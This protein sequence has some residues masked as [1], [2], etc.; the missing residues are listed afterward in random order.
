MGILL[1]NP[2]SLALLAAVFIVVAVLFRIRRIPLRTRLM[3]HVGLAVALAAVLHMVR[4]YQMPQGGSI[5][6]G[7][8]LPLLLVGLWHGP[9]AGFLAGFLFGT[10]NLIQGPYILH[11][12]QVLFDYPLPFM[13]LGLAGYFPTRPWF[14]AAVGVT[15]RFLCHY[16]SGVVFFASYAPPGISPYWYSLVFNATYLVPELVICLAVLRA[17]P[18]ERIKSAKNGKDF[19]HEKGGNIHEN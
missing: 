16:I 2:A 7:S 18:I 5:T 1:A 19:Q 3:T 15:G 12:A 9:E 14:G 8:M 13:A 4:L 6:L 10:V 17:L 11:P